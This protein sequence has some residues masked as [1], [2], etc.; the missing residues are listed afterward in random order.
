MSNPVQ[1]L[2]Q[3]AKGKKSAYILIYNNP[4]PDGLASAWALKEIFQLNKVT[5]NI[6][7]TGQVGRLQNATMIDSLKLPAFP[8]DPSQMKKADLLATVDAQPSFFQGLDLPPFD[9]V[10]DHHPGHISRKVTF[11]DQRPRCLATASILCEYLQSLK[12][13]LSK[14]LATALYYGVLTDSRGQQ[15]PFSEEDEQALE[16][17]EKK[18]D[19]NLI[20]RIEF[21]QYSLNDLEYFKLAFLKYRFARHLM[22]VHLGPVPYT[23]VCVQAAELLMPVQE[24]HWVVVSGVVGQKLVIVFRCDGYKKHAGNL[25]Q[26]AFGDRGS[27][28]GHRTMARAE[29]SAEALPSDLGLTQNEGLE[30]FVVQSLARH[31][32]SFNAL[33]KLLKERGLEDIAKH[34]KT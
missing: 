17:L 15:K 30:C 27:A 16:Y 18:A 5:A 10:I 4:D 25:A 2:A 23:D 14:R 9:L 19:K 34:V 13:P 1:Q 33:V 31:D 32:R 26:K 22:F 7:Y 24:V 28:G 12:F 20:R 8:W 11:I 21:S 6:G 29:I 3:L